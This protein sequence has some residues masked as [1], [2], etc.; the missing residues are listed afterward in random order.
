MH[1]ATTLP[2]PLSP[3]VVG[4]GRA[5][6]CSQLRI[7]AGVEPG[8]TDSISAA[9][10]ETSGAEKLVPTVI[11]KLSEKTELSATGAVVPALRA[12]RIGYW[13]AAPGV[14]STQLPPGA[15]SA[16]SG[17]RSEKP[18]LVPTW[19][20][21]RDRDH[22]G[23]V[24]RRA[25]RMAGR[26]AGRRDDHGARRQLISAMVAVVQ[27]RARAR[28][29]EAQVDDPRRRRIGRHAGHREAGGPAHAGD[30]VGVETAALAEHAHRQHA[31]VAADAGHAEAV[32]GGRRRSAPR[33]R[34]R[35]S[36]CC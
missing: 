7:S 12:V 8:R 21:A 30:D 23:A 36:C 20:S 19:R 25:D 5:H 27:R 9:V 32:V 35:A 11:W 26:I 4:K 14:M 22:A 3:P 33:L 28:A 13:Q 2:S 6:C 18:T 34:C 29:A 31:H 1:W 10:P 16:I 15:L 17:P 24:G